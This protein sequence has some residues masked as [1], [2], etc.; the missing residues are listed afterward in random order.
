MSSLPKLWDTVV[1]TINSSQG[2]DKLKFYV[3]RDVILS[4]SIHKWEIWDSS[5]NPL[6]VDQRGRSKSKSPN[7]HGRSKS[8]NRRKSPSKSNV[9]CW[10]CREK[11]YFRTKCTKLKKK[12]NHKS[13]DNNDSSIY[14]TEDTEDVLILRVDSLI[15]WWIL[16]SGALFHSCPSKE[17][18]RRCILPTTK[19]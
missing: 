14:L 9:K 11:G 16:D 7:K 4:K 2:F 3:I 17:I 19:P 5:G 13:E 6:S 15:G 10:N 12:Q 8:K 1:V 18:L